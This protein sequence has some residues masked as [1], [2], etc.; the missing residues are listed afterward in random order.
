MV[1]VNHPKYPP[2]VIDEK[3][4]DKFLAL[5]WTVEE[6]EESEESEDSPVPRKRGRPAKEQ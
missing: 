3:W 4:L 1:K 6:T 5:G 2:Q